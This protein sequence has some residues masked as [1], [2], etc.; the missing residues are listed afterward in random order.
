MNSIIK[1]CKNHGLCQHNIGK[2]SKIRCSKCASEAVQRRRDKI[3]V[4]A[5]EYKGNKCSICDYNKCIGA[6][7]FHHLDPNEK[8]FGISAKGY[9]RS[10]ELVKKELD[11]CILVCSNC[12]RELHYTKEI[13]IVEKQ[14]TILEEDKKI[15]NKNKKYFCSNC[16]KELSENTKTGLCSECYKITTRKI[17]RPLKEELFEMIKIKPF[18][19]IGK[20]Y[21]VTD[22][23][24]RKWCKD[25][26][27]PST[28]KE[29]Q[30]LGLISNFSS[31]PK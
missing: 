19:E 9:T 21:G 27:I 18:T 17:E 10:W 29:L 3:K 11:K 4:M 24:I 2:D 30:E 5:I 14:Y 25:Y 8:E 28:K 16:S 6:L 26:N 23:S 20:V 12:H 13:E 22:N 7:E 15:E 31:M 1:E